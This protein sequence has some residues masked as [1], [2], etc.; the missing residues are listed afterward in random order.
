VAA[1]YCAASST[2][3]RELRGWTWS[4]SEKTGEVSAAMEDKKTRCS[5]WVSRGR[6]L[7]NREPD[8]SL[9]VLLRRVGVVRGVMVPVPDP[10]GDQ[11]L[12]LVFSAL[13]STPGT[14]QRHQAS[15]SQHPP[16]PEKSTPSYAPPALRL[17]TDVGWR[18]SWSVRRSG[19]VSS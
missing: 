12:P 18:R 7:S 15:C 13:T 1:A 14:P 6:T 9:P 10:V 16:R 3:A 8:E 11:L 19:K 17:Q 2:F 4:Q 5:L